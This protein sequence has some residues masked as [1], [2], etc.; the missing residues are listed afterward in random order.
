MTISMVEC[1]LNESLIYN[2]DDVSGKIKN[3]A[4][5]LKYNFP[6]HSIHCQFI[7]L[8]KETDR[9]LDKLKQTLSA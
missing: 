8:G 3:S 9:N 4:E 7:G 1:S 5:L 6:L 2:L